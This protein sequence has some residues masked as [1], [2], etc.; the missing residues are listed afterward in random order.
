MVCTQ[1]F[2]EGIKS[3]NV[4]RNIMY[5]AFINICNVKKSIEIYKYIDSVI[6]IIIV[7]N[8]VSN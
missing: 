1:C 4:I 3:M 5:V 2:V 7:V 8:I 6:H